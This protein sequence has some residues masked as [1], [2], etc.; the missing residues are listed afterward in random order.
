MIFMLHIIVL[1]IVNYIKMTILKKF[2]F[3]KDFLIDLKF[4][5][6]LFIQSQGDSSSSTL[7][8]FVK[9][10]IWTW[11]ITFAEGPCGVQIA[12]RLPARV[13]RQDDGQR[14][15]TS[16]LLQKVKE[17]AWTQVTAE[18]PISKHPVRRHSPG[19]HLMSGSGGR[20]VLIMQTRRLTLDVLKKAAAPGR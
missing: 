2:H 16:N 8:M 18:Q 12:C 13:I 11:A 20:R 5:I 3:N 14:G 15:N 7:D 19:W 17:A 4:I 9:L 10:M 6:Q 1:I